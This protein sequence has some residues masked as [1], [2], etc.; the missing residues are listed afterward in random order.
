MVIIFVINV[1]QFSNWALT[2]NGG[3]AEL[4]YLAFKKWKMTTSLLETNS[5]L[6]FPTFQASFV[7]YEVSVVDYR[8]VLVP[9]NWYF[10][11]FKSRDKTKSYVVSIFML[12]ASC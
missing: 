8:N 7:S 2:D 12:L 9:Y 10:E 3:M 4:C 5:G 6:Q 1:V 11:E